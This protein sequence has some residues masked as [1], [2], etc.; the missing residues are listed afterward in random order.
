MRIIIKVDNA[1]D[2]WARAEGRSSLYRCL[3]EHMPSLTLTELA[4]R[5][6]PVRDYHGGRGGNDDR[7]PYTHAHTR[8]WCGYQECRES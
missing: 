5:F 1:G 8:S 4:A 3:T 7:C 6:G 2:V